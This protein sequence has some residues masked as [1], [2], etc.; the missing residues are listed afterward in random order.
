MA[1]AHSAP[2]TLAVE[3]LRRRIDQEKDRGQHRRRGQQAERARRAPP[4]IVAVDDGVDS[5]HQRRRYGHGAADIEPSGGRL[6]AGLR[7]QRAAQGIDR[8]ADRQ[9]HEKY[10]VPAGRARQHAAREHAEAAAAGADETIDTH[11]LG[12]V[13]RLREEI[14]DER[15]RDR[16]Y[17][18]AAESL[19]RACADE[20]RLRAGKAAGEGGSGENSDAV[21]EK[22]PVAEQVAEP[23]AKQQ[24]TAVSE[25]IGVHDPDERG[26]REAQAF[27]DR[28]QGDVHDRRVEH[29][30]QLAGAKDVER[31][32]ARSLAHF[33]ASGMGA[34]VTF[35]RWL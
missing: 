7:N 14:H 21:K 1:A 23:P 4:G 32:P 2:T 27:L 17:H 5:E 18:G 33:F 6:S 15:E 20:Q 12:A 29:D 16:R 19:H 34:L 24:E 3:R 26:L 13:A 11:R 8:D 22:A 10:P 31:E 28:R 9:I 35:R 25:H 30:H